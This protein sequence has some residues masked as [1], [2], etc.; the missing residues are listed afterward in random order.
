MRW[1]W[2]VLGG[3]GICLGQ[4]DQACCRGVVCDLDTLDGLGP[5]GANFAILAPSG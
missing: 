4:F 2:E 1:A 5:L 3:S